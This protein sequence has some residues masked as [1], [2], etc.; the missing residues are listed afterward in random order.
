MST[1]TCARPVGDRDGVLGLCP[2]YWVYTPR[3][4]PRQLPGPIVDSAFNPWGSRLSG[5]FSDPRPSMYPSRDGK[6]RF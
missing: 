3:S 1:L 2:V 4:R 5:L 6:V